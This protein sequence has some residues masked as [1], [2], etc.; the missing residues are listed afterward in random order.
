[1]RR[2]L[3]TGGSRG[4]GLSIARRLAQDGHQV[5]ITYA[6][7]AKGAADAVAQA[8][9][10][11]LTLQA[12]ACD[13]ADA[14]AFSALR[15]AAG[16]AEKDSPADA[17]DFHVLVHAAGFTRD[18]LLLNMATADFDDV[19]G[20]HLRGA[21]LSTQ[22]VLRGMIAARFG[23]IVYITSPTATLGRRG[24][25]NYGAAK[26]GLVGLMKSLVCEVSRFRV[27]VN[28]VSAGLIDTALTS[29]LSAEVKSEL[30]GTIPMQRP[31]RPEEVAA[32]VAFL[33]SPAAG[34][35][36]GQTLA[37]DGGLDALSASAEAW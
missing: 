32:L 3:V 33:A 28:C 16:N 12:V 22:A 7:D 17:H 34:Y 2:A 19:V 36:T 18:R 13:A 15:P 5:T 31:G 10:D 26:A 8:Q 21:F 27:T 29:A 4:I 20:V 24:Q 6:H 11:G 30:V 25:C 35:I 14:T 23:R 37:V 1:M 9:A